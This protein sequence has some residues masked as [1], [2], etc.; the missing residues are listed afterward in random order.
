[1]QRRQRVAN[2][3]GVCGMRLSIVLFRALP[4]KPSAL[5]CSIGVN[6]MVKIGLT[7]KVRMD[8]KV[9]RGH[10]DETYAKLG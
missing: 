8:A 10:W 7:S 2:L 1:M 4:A 6:Q 3:N 9:S 5:V